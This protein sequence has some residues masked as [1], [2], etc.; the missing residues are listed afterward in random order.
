[1]IENQS[2]ENNL[3]YLWIKKNYKKFNFDHVTNIL[4]DTSKFQ[5]YLQNAI[6]IID[7]IVDPITPSEHGYSAKFNLGN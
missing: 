3:L 1:M 7:I 6:A 2:K 5:Y 4:I